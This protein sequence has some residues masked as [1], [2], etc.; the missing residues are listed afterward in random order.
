MSLGTTLYSY[1]PLTA[2]SGAGQLYEENGPLADDALRRDYNW[3]GAANSR[4]VRSDAGAVLY[5]QSFLT[6]SLGRLT[7]TINEL[8]TFTAGYTAANLSPNMNTWSH[9]NGLSITFDRYAA[10]AGSNALGLQ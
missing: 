10:N 4:Q 2:V 1:K 5:S 7:Q 3:Q 8:G 6:D 9:P